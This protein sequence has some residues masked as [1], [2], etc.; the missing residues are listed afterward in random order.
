MNLIYAVALFFAFQDTPYKAN[1]EFELKLNFEFRQR[2]HDP[3][4]YKFNGDGSSIPQPT[5]QLPYLKV[6]LKLLKLSAAETRVRVVNHEQQNILSK[7]A[8][9]GQLLELDLGFTDDLKGRVSSHEY[10]A[11]LL[12]SEKKPVSRI[13]ILFQEDGSYLVN[14]EKRGKI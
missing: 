11:L 14:G 12:D 5:G 7:K 6:N 10:T 9:E 13:V 8:Q 2:P 1:E 3:N 4:A